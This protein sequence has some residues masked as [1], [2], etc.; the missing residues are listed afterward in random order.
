M[1]ASPNSLFEREPD[2]AARSRRRLFR[3]R[4][5]AQRPRAPGA[6]QRLLAWMEDA[7]RRSQTPG[8]D[9]AAITLDLP[10][11]PGA[12]PVKATIGRDRVTFTFLP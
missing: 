8:H 6:A 1:M 10:A 11:M 12:G 7:Y 3:H 9:A 5:A 4:A 2:P